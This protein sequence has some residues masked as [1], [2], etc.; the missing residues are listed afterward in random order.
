[1]FDFSTKLLE[2]AYRVPTMHQQQS[3]QSCTA[4]DVQQI[5]LFEHYFSARLST[6]AAWQRAAQLYP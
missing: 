3:E 4:A 5:T 1:M 2:G 6:E